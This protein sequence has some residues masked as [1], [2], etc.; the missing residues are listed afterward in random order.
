MNKNIIEIINILIKKF[1]GNKNRLIDKDDIIQ[2][3]INMGYEVDDIDFA[4][5]LLFKE[6]IIEENLEEEI[7][8][9]YNRIFTISEKVYIPVEIRGL[10]HRLIFLN[11]L[12]AQESET[13]IARTVQDSYSGISET[14]DIWEILED[15]IKDE[16]KLEL[17]SRKIPEFGS[18]YGN[19][20][21]HI[22]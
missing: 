12:S 21:E 9:N 1:L 3:L 22:N 7:C 2:E 14:D 19:E 13:L 15:I 8:D 18:L 16:S 11:V 20:F 5:D 10:I 4:M 6:E 17:I